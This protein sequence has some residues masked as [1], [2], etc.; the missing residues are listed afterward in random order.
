M[1]KEQVHKESEELNAKHTYLRYGQSV[2][3]Y[4]SSVD[5]ELARQVEDASDWKIF[6][7]VD[8]DVDMPELVDRFINTFLTKLKDKD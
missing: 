7:I 1:T 8:G 3:T 4:C 2:W 5:P 6:Y